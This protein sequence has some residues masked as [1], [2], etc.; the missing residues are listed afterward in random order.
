MYITRVQKMGHEDSEVPVMEMKLAFVVFSFSVLRR[1]YCSPF[2]FRRSEK[3]DCSSSCSTR[4]PNLRRLLIR[5]KS[6][7]FEPAK[8][9]FCHCPS[10]QLLEPMVS[11]IQANVRSIVNGFVNED[12]RYREVDIFWH[13]WDFYRMAGPWDNPIF[14]VCSWF[15]VALP[16]NML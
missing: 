2:V 11:C 12:Y 16:I 15:I 7:I 3:A 4:L 14:K 9:A 5:F 13:C 10:L 1:R 8:K 6:R